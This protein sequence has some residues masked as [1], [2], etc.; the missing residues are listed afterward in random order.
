MKSADHTSKLNQL[1]VEGKSPPDPIYTIA[2]METDFTI[3]QENQMTV[4][5][6]VLEIRGTPLLWHMVRSH[7]QII[8]SKN[9]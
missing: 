8:Q 6:L 1:E 7:W 4:F 5:L 3:E 2:K 9:G